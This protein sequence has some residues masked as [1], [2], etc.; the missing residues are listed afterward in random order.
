VSNT[1]AVECVCITGPTACGKTD[2]ALAL[3]ERV[4]LEVISMD[5]AMVYRGL[6]IGTAKPSPEI[7]SAVPHHLVD[8]LDPTESYSAGRFAQDAS[9]AISEIRARGRLPL[10]VGGTL[11]YLRALRDGLSALPRAD[12]AVRAELDREAEQHGWSSLHERLQ[13][14]DPAAARRIA[15]SDRQRI[16]R[17]LEVHTLTGR[18]ITELQAAGRRAHRGPIVVL[19]LVPENRSELAARIERRFD[20]MVALGFVAE[21]ERLRARDELRPDLPAMRAVGYRQLWAHLDGHFGWDEARSKAII[22]TRQYAKRQLTWLRGD[23]NCEVW[24]ALAPGLVERCLDRLSKENLI[25][26]NSRGL[27]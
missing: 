7:R 21:V 10:L 4:P 16:Q 25:A 12:R 20:A 9:R 24:P 22:A 3:A 14:V 23:P 15:P 19:A 13:R 1:A 5:S 18:P 26:K 11:L 8:L 6:D 27:C 2:L 17:A